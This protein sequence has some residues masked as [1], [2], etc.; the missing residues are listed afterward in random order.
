MVLLDS[1][2]RVVIE[3]HPVESSTYNS[4]ALRKAVAAQGYNRWD[5]Q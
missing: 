4:Q 2:G 3:F 1:P 5:S